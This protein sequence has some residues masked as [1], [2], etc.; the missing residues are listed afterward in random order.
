MVLQIRRVLFRVIE[1]SPV[2]PGKGNTAC[3]QIS[4]GFVQII[5]PC[6]LHRVTDVL[7]LIP[8]ILLHIM[9][10]FSVHNSACRNKGQYH[11]K[12]HHNP[13][14]VQ[15]TLFHLPSP[16][17]YPTPRMVS[18]RLP[19]SP[20]FCRSVRICTST[21]LVSPSKSYPQMCSSSL[22]RLSTIP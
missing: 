2:R 22:S 5:F 18:I 13:Y 19:Q 8:H 17:R 21:V 11:G 9:I 12:N 6:I 1:D 14:V 7:G 16:I 4:C 15:Y 20:S 10:V 3:C